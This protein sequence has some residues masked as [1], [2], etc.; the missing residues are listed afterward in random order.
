MFFNWLCYLIAMVCVGFSTVMFN[1]RFFVILLIIGLMLPIVSLICMLRMHGKL[2]ASIHAE[3][4]PVRSGENFPFYVAVT[5]RGSIPCANIRIRVAV[6]D[7]L[8]GASRIIQRMA[9]VP[10]KTVGRAELEIPSTH[11]GRVGIT[12]LQVVVSVPFGFFRVRAKVVS[13][14]ADFLIYP[15]MVDAGLTLVQPNPYAYIADEEYSQTRPG[16]DPS[17][18][19]GVREYRPGDRQNRIHWNLTASR[20]ITMVKELGLPIDTSVLVLADIYAMPQAVAEEQYDALMTVIASVVRRLRRDRQIFYI[21]WLTEPGNAWHM[22][23]AEDEEWE[24]V[25]TQLFCVHPYAADCSVTAGYA[26]RFADERYRNILYITNRW[27][28]SSALGLETLRAEANV[29]VLFVNDERTKAPQLSKGE[30]VIRLRAE[31]LTED[32]SIAADAEL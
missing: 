23:I 17:E 14:E 5:N 28:E 13:P 25:Q 22:R 19:F 29:T 10:G 27:T 3:G 4:T 20:D 2:F 8:A 30:R 24:A 32:L 16:D 9:A 6:E 26:Q 11:C 7:V 15:E 21:G 1:N 12:L 18:L 31:H